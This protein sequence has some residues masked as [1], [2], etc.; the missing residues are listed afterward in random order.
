MDVYGPAGDWREN[1]RPPGQTLCDQV[2]ESICLMR[3]NAKRSK[4]GVSRS[5]NSIMSEDSSDEE[6]NRI[7][8][9]AP[10]P[11]AM[12]C[13]LQLNQHRETCGK[14]GQYKTK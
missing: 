3:R 10:M 9:N 12:P 6:F 1:K 7:M 4:S 11:A 14:V 8:K 13:R 2:C 5:P